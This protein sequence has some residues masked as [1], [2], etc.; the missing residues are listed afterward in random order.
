MKRLF[1]YLI[2]AMIMGL[3]LCGCGRTTDQGNVGTSPWPEMTVPA[4]PVPTAALSPLPDLNMEKGA[5][6]TGSAASTA[7]PDMNTS[8]P[9][10]TS[11]PEISGSPKPTDTSK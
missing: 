4:T 7:A 10:M 8:T 2:L 11:S 3:L 6:G 9:S 5:N 1:A